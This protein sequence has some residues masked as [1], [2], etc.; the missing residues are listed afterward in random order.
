MWINDPKKP[1]EASKNLGVP[2]YS[3]KQFLGQNYHFEKTEH[4]I[5]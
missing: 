5:I 3:Q 2:T 4:V 1:N